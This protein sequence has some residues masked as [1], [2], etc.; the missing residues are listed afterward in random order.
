M[1]L[2]YQQSLSQITRQTSLGLKTDTQSIFLSAVS[3]N[4]SISFGNVTTAFNNQ[5]NGPE[6]DRFDKWI[7][8]WP[9]SGGVQTALNTSADSRT[10]MS[11]WQFTSDA[12]FNNYGGRLDANYAYRDS[13]RIGDAVVSQ[14]SNLKSI[15]EVAHEVINGQW[16]DG[17]NRKNNLTNAGYNYSEVQDRVNAILGASAQPIKKSIDEIANEVLSGAWGNGSDRKNNLE[18]AGYDY[19]EVQNK[20]NEILGAN[21]KSIDEIA[22]EVINGAWGDGN[23]RKSNLEAAGY[24]YSEVQNKV[25]EILGANKN[26]APAAQM[27]IIKSGDTLSKI[28]KKYGTTW[29]EIYN[30]NRDVISN[31][32]IIRAGMKIKI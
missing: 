27:Y 7:A 31:P 25:N 5:L 30:K 22:R 28:A 14:P 21:K 4:T 3:T 8:Q 20:V 17:Q 19:N 24:N 1:P 16:G 11:M 10:G 6:L 26:S 15:D 23:T 12:R 32:N 29:Q 18:A 13:Y 9:T 2:S